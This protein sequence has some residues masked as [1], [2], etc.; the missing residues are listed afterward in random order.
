MKKREGGFVKISIKK[1]E[2]DLSV[3]IEDNG[4]GI[5][6]SIIDSLDKQINENIGLKNVHQRLKLLYG[7]GLEI[8]KLAKGTKISFKILGGKNND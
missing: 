3:S 1:L 2:N 4:V 7:K 6:Q 8:K 5:E